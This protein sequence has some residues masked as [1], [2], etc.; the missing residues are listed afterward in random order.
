M[1]TKI[2]KN[3]SKQQRY[4]SGFDGKWVKY[5]FGN[6]QDATILYNSLQGHNC[7][8][9]TAGSLKVAK[10]QILGN[11]YYIGGD[12]YVYYTYDEKFNPV[13]PRIAIRMDGTDTIG[14][15]RG[16]ADQSQNVEEGFEDIIKSKLEEIPTL[17]D[18]SRKEQLWI[19]EDLRMLTNLNQKV[20]QKKE[21]SY[22]EKEFIFE[23]NR[24]IK[25]FG[26]DYDKRILEIRSYTS[27]DDINMAIKFIT[28]NLNNRFPPFNEEIFKYIKP[29]IFNII[30]DDYELL[31]KAFKN[32]YKMILKY[33]SPKIT[34]EIL[35]KDDSLGIG[36]T[37][38][39]F[40]NDFSYV[41]KFANLLFEETGSCHI[42]RY[43]SENLK[44][45]KAFIIALL[46]L[47]AFNIN[48]VPD[49]LV[50]DPEVIEAAINSNVPYKYTY[51][52]YD[53]A[54]ENLSKKN[55]PKR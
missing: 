20:K 37:N 46:K 24:A 11:K 28:N 19:I 2:I 34:F 16:V 42:L 33:C 21:L 47:D 26:F 5:N 39:R 32:N 44:N 27:I 4:E 49:E 52:K 10:G 40:R 29:D 53:E 35:E 30:T 50:I 48:F 36:D 7:P 38:K 22:Q 45:N 1:Y 54:K 51:L 17:T 15:I 25:T 18:E 41:M 23:C 6:E 14:E 31:K 3:Y 13:I 55:E 12:F 43:C 9:C 8:W